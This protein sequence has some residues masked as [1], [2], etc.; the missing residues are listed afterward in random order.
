LIK[1]NTKFRW[2]YFDLDGTLADSIPESYRA[3]I[4]FLTKFGVTGGMEE[5]NQLNGLSFPETTAVLKE[6]YQL[7]GTDKSLADLYRQSILDAYN[8]SIQLCDG[9]FDVL[10]KLSLR[11][12]K[13]AIVTSA[14]QEI[15]MSFVDNH[16]LRSYFHSF[17][18]GDEVEKSKPDPA[19]YRLALKKTD[20][21]S[22]N[23]VVVEDAYNGVKSAKAIGAFV[24]G[25][26]NNQS[27]EDLLGAGADTVVSKLDEILTIL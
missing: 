8:G 9:V 14:A 11:K 3:H 10:D 22:E 17:V 4:R 7:P 1:S 19:I 12:Y 13:L 6:R 15:C 25:V 23:V 24:I 27:R 2:V 26:T 18:F 21:S 5:F 20:A 16:K